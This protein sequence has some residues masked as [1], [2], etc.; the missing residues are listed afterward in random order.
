MGA[1][2]ADSNPSLHG[3][4]HSRQ[5]CIVKAEKTLASLFL[6]LICGVHLL[7]ACGGGVAAGNNG[8]GG[9]NNGGGGSP[10]QVV[11]HF[12]V[13]AP[14]SANPGVS[15]SFTVTALDAANQVVTTYSG[16]VRFASTDGKATLP[17]NSALTNGSGNFLATLNTAGNQTITATDFSAALITGTSFS[18]QV[19]SLPGLSITSG[20]P[21]NGTVSAKYGTP[22]SIKCSAVQKCTFFYFPLT[23]SENGGN[24]TWAATPG[25]SLPPGLACCWLLTET[26]FPGPIVPITIYP[27]IF[28][29][30][31]A[32]G[33]FEV[34]VTVSESLGV[35][36]SATYTI[37]IGA[38]AAANAA[39]E[40]TANSSAKHHHY[41]LIDMGTFGGPSSAFPSLNSVGAT[42]GWSATSVLKTA[43]S[44]PLICG[45]TDDVGAYVT[46]GFEW[47]DGTIAKLG[48]LS[49]EGSCSIPSRLNDEGEIVGTSENSEFDPLAGINQ[50]RAVRWV[51]GKIQD[52]GSF[53]GNQNTAFY[54]NNR[55]QIVGSSQNSI[56]DP[57]SCWG[58][59]STQCRAFLWQDGVM[60][61]LGTLGGPD[62]FAA[63]ISERGEIAGISY[64]GSIP[65][66]V[67]GIPPLDA[68]LWKDGRMV[69]LGTFGGASSFPNAVNNRG[70]VIG[71]ASFPDAL[72]SC[73]GENFNPG[74]DPFLWSEGKLID[75][76]TSTTGGN[77]ITANEISDDG[78]IIGAAAFPYAPYDAYVWRNGV[79]TDLGHLDGDCF[80]EAR[81]IN[82]EGQIVGDSFACDGTFHRAFLW[83]NGS[84]VDLNALVPPDSSL[85]LAAIGPFSLAPTPGPLN[86]GGEIG[87]NGVPPG[88]PP[89]VVGLEAQGHAFLLIPCDENHPH[90]DGCDYS[91]AD[92]STVANE[93]KQA[94]VKPT[95]SPEVVKQR[96]QSFGSR[97]SPW[98]RGFAVQ[99]PK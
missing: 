46:V 59:S 64:T 94:A 74:C 33:S 62:A 5:R 17:P 50:S 61:D 65:N 32:A 28:G 47:L 84:I 72:G 20:P 81:A 7:G 1:V 11:T 27:V 96:M 55:G 79:A 82:S 9:G 36:A 31:T 16:T 13:S 60:E 18:I 99:V 4:D 39:A 37:T 97:T 48:A 75:L 90:I 92:A 44:H 25:S 68:F 70:Q 29:T 78:A 88:V 66:P 51:H 12:S 40:A 86:D 95:L 67:T 6:L 24:W 21:P 80:S 2:T 93:G 77:P 76:N 10:Q 43:T 26:T 8:G 71:G 22:H 52:L 57:F 89:A 91:L 87:G 42:V 56:A 54:V 98:R 38:A 58:P 19:N 3:G 35:Q 14:G 83:E 45:G 53:G 49:G 73:L 34:T 15:F 23:A 63:F 85:Q 69:D 30:P 41:K